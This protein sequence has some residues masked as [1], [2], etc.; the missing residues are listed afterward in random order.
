MKIEENDPFP[1]QTCSLWYFSPTSPPARPFRNAAGFEA[2]IGA[3]LVISQ[4]SV[5]GLSVFSESKVAQEGQ[6]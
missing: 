3:F 2:G 1:A 6:P 5:V 4:E